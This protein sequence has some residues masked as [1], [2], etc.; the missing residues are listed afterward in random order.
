MHTIHMQHMCRTSGRAEESEKR[1]RSDRPRGYRAANAL[2]HTYL[3]VFI[4]QP[5]G[6]VHIEM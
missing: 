3:L 6:T 2:V 1:G 5:L 4:T